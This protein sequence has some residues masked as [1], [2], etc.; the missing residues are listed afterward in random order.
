MELRPPFYYTMGQTRQVLLISHCREQHSRQSVLRC[1]KQ[2]NAYPR[3][4][5]N[6][7]LFTASCR[8]LVLVDILVDVDSFEKKKKKEPPIDRM[9][10][11]RKSVC[12]VACCPKS[13]RKAN[14]S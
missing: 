11:S 14:K 2:E 5:A 4:R 10:H 1:F 3:S 13:K 8:Y 7:A 6:A 9:V 12:F